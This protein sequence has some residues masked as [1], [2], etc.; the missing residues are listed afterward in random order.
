MALTATVTL[1]QNEYFTGLVNFILFMRLYATNTSNRQKSIVDELC[2]ETLTYGDKK[3]YPFAELP[4]VVDYSLTSSL[5]TDSPIKYTEEFIGD[6]P[7]KKKISLSTI[8][9]YMEMAMMS[10]SGV[11]AFFAYLE[12]LMQSAKY[13]YLYNQIMTDLLSWTPTTTTGKEMSKT[14]SMIDTSAM[15]SAEE[16]KASKELNMEET[17]ASLQKVY[18]DLSIFTD[19]F[20]DVDNTANSSNFKTAVEK[21]DLLLIGNAKFMNDKII[22]WLSQLLKPELIDKNF[23]HPVALKVPQRTFDDNSKSDIMFIVCHRH[24]YQWFYRFTFMGSFY[25]IDTVRLKQV[26]H[27]WYNRGRLKN[28]PAVKFTASYT[29][30]GE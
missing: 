29:T 17:E 15:T 13:D 4:K 12:G 5:L 8:R 11:T 7:I 16:I 6:T 2:T 10:A 20:I 22:Y 18:D 27:F 21:K 30:L 1:N 3:A 24:W 26:L 28:L 25:D 14:I 23:S 9:P 19:V